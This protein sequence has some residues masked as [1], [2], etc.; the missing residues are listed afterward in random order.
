MPT[1]PQIGEPQV[2]PGIP[3]LVKPYAKGPV[4]L[5][6]TLGAG[7]SDLGV[8]MQREEA[9]EKAKANTAAIGNALL[10]L[11]TI[12]TDARIGF[13]KLEGNDAGLAAQPTVEGYEKARQKIM[14]G[15]TPEQQGEFARASGQRSN[16]FRQYVMTKGTSEQKGYYD[17]TYK[18]ELDN[19]IARVLTTA[20][21]GG[22]LA[23]E[24]PQGPRQ[25]GDDSPQSEQE[26]A[27][28]RIEAY[29]D[30][31]D[32]ELGMPKEEWL[33]R[34]KEGYD[35]AYTVAVVE[36][37][38]KADDDEGAEAY[39]KANQTK[40][41]DLKARLSLGGAVEARG[42]EARTE[43]TATELLVLANE[44][45]KDGL[46]P[47][48]E[49]KN[50]R[51]RN[52]IDELPFADRKAVRD[53]VDDMEAEADED[54][55]VAQSKNF[56]ILH[57]ALQGGPNQ[58]PLP[59]R[60]V[61]KLPMF[62]RDDAG[63]IN[64]DQRDALRVYSQR[65]TEGDY[66]ATTPEVWKRLTNLLQTKPGELLKI[67]LREL[68]DAG[69]LA[70]TDAA[71]VES[72]QKAIG[73][74]GS[75]GAGASDDID[76]SMT[77]DQVRKAWAKKAGLSE[78]GAVDFELA[79]LDQ[80]RRATRAKGAPLTDV[81]YDTLV[82]R[83]TIKVT[84]DRPWYRGGDVVGAVGALSDEG[85]DELLAHPESV[86]FKDIPLADVEEFRAA[87]V[88]QGLK[89]DDESLRVEWIKYLRRL[90]AS[91]Q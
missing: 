14:A 70:S 49:E 19:S 9:R 78:A 90:K 48:E 65:R 2:A 69:V 23:L 1:I 50:R 75:G 11:D 4:E 86:E 27:Y 83:A 79:L 89:A 57:A 88:G 32:G 68:T 77:R 84:F 71:E 15:L 56:D 16:N 10:Q 47:T 33:R 64:P 34:Q 8:S 61:E 13:D 59:L 45:G 26:A 6:A 67:N 87:L 30:A 53:R 40:I 24:P 76:L 17:D 7:I 20:E 36:G 25:E 39:Y 31:H 62:L 81:E 28:D 72:W 46:P 5:G 21:Q 73:K 80:E 74:A 42:K 66:A 51:I 85:L 35:S 29:A 12:E 41:T 37:L 54:M 63:G 3:P 58:A 22:V 60:E 91:G 18:N 55:R 52:G 82:Q 38:L 44:P 43:R